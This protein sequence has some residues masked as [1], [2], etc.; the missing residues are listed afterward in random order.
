MTELPPDESRE[1]TETFIE[2]L[3]ENDGDLL[4]EYF[5]LLKEDY[6][7]DELVGSDRYFQFGSTDIHHIVDLAVIFGMVW[8]REDPSEE[9]DD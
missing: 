2:Y 9:D 8:E 5:R 4:A 3:A 1:D 6:Y 7:N